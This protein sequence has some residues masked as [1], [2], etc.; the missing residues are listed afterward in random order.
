MQAY[1]QI[2]PPDA[3]PAYFI[4]FDIDP[5]KIDINIHPTK[6]EIK[7]EDELAIWQILHAVVRE[8]I[9]RYNLSPS[10]DFQTEGVVDIPVLRKDTEIRILP[11]DI[12]PDFNPFDEDKPGNPV[13][14]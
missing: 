1:E 6:T 7:F 4:Y 12:N 8:S 13:N 2:L 14:K 5:D 3:I 10:M 11:I 9:G